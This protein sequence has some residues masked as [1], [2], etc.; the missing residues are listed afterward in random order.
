MAA[1]AYYSGEKK[2]SEYD[3]TWK[4]PHSD[5]NRVQHVEVMLPPN[6][7]REYADPERLWNA[8]DASEESSV[9]QTARKMEL[10]L[11]REL[12]Y[13]DNLQLIRDYCQYE[14]VDKGMVCNF[15]YHDKGDGNPHVHIM[16]TVRAMDEQGK[17]LPKSKN[18][19][20]LDEDGNRIRGKN[21]KWI[22]QKIDTVDWNDHKYGEIWRHDWETYQNF[23]L[24]MAG[25]PE[26]V[27]MRSL[28][29]QGVTDRVPQVHLGPAAAAMER[30]GTPTDKAEENRNRFD[31]NKALAKIQGTITSLANWIEELKNL[32]T[33]QR[34]I[35]NPGDYP[36]AEVITSYLHL[37]EA[38]RSSW[39][40]YAQNKAG[41]KDLQAGFDAVHFM[42]VHQL[43]TVNDLGD[44]IGEQRSKVKAAK[45]KLSS[46]KSETRDI[47]DL[48]KVIEK[49][50]TLEP[51][52]TG[53]D[54]TWKPFKAKY[55]EEHKA[56]LADYK[57]SVALRDK[58]AAKLGV[59]LPLTPAKRKKLNQ[60]KDKLAKEK[61]DLEPLLT[62]MQQELK[63]YNKLRYWTRKAYPDAAEALDFRI[64][65]K[66]AYA[67]RSDLDGDPDPNIPEESI[68]GNRMEIDRLMESTA[69]DALTPPDQRNRDPAPIPPQRTQ[70]DVLRQK[71]TRN[72]YNR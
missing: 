12:S 71:K 10:A 16:L 27:D 56:E 69:A 63:E 1:C 33:H 23:A 13:E 18:V 22:R 39:S 2:F 59:E 70:E 19:Y 57:K 43:Y 28:E 55:Y 54:K 3:G 42:K 14:F 17:W 29:R 67:N 11:P 61:T 38:E 60:R 62:E 65:V 26:R 46:I 25:R 58:L 47:D 50:E 44:A 49:L 41:V 21:G 40:R 52:K 6:A 20:V 53:Y 7:P 68:I 66:D 4:Y 45:A 48:L 35:E 30:K 8:V 36:V 37:R 34:V 31:I 15:F 9:A 72:D 5:P 24:E 51:V 64:S 32:I